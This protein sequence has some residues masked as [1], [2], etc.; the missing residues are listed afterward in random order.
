[1]VPDLHVFTEC[2]G[3][4][5]DDRRVDPDFIRAAAQDAGARWSA[6]FFPEEP[7][8]LIQR[9]T[10]V[11]L[12]RVW[13]EKCQQRVASPEARRTHHERYQQCEPLRLRKNATVLPV[14]VI[15]EVYRPK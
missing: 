2:N 1:M 12:I 13:P 14:L 3:V 11:R 5:P 6:K 15:A 8:G 7:H 4:A 10:S 9:R